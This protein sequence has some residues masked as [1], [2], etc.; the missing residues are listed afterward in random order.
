MSG[1]WTR[2]L[3]R[4]RDKTPI[5]WLGAGASCQAEPPL[6]T[7]GQ[8]VG[9]LQERETMWRPPSEL[10]D[11][12]AL[13]DH[14]VDEFSEGELQDFLAKQL[15]PDGRTPQ[16]GP[17]HRHLATLVGGRRFEAIIDT[18]YDMLLRHACEERGAAFEFS[19]L[20]RN[21]HLSDHDLPRYLALH[22][23]WDDW[24]SIVLTGRSFEAYES[25]HPLAI[26]EL[27]LQ[28]RRHPVLLVGCSLQDPRLLRWICALSNQD[29]RQLKR[30]VAVLGPG[31]RHALEQARW[32]DGRSYLEVLETITIKID[33][34]ESYDE[35]PGLF[36]ALASEVVVSHR[37]ELT[38]TIRAGERWAVEGLGE[39]IEVEPPKLPEDIDALRKLACK[40]LPCDQSGR[41]DPKTEG[42]YRA[43]QVRAIAA[44]EALAAVLPG[45]ARD[46][47]TTLVGEAAGEGAATLRLRATGDREQVDAAMLLPWEMISVDGLLPVGDGRLHLVREVVVPGGSSLPDDVGKP[48]VVAHV[49]TP[50]GSGIAE[51]D[52]E[53]AS[54]RIARALA[55]LEGFVRFTDWGTLDDLGEAVRSLG[56]APTIL[57]FSG[58]GRPGE[59]LFED[60]DGG[61]AWVGI[62]SLCERLSVATDGTLPAAIWLSCCYGAGTVVAPSK[63]ARDLAADVANAPELVRQASVASELHRRG[64]A[65]VL[66]YF[67][68]VSDPLAARLDC[69][70]FEALVE[71]GHT[72]DAVRRARIGSKTKLE[73]SY[74]WLRFPLA[75]AML[76]LYH[77]G[78]DRKL[79]VGERERGKVLEDGLAPE[80][81][82]FEGSDLQV[83]EHGYIG[84]RRLLAGLRRLRK[85]AK[86]R[87]IGLYGLGGLGKT[88]AMMRF[89]MLLV[90]TKRVRRDVIAIPAREFAAESTNAAG[91]VWLLDRIKTVIDTHPRKPEDWD[92]RFADLD[93]SPDRPAALARL[94]LA[95]A[96]GG[97]IY[98][99]NLETLQDA[100]ASSD[101][102]VPWRD[103]RLA[104]FFAVLTSEVDANTT[105]L[106]TSR[107]RPDGGCGWWRELG[108]CSK[109]E[110]FRMTGWWDPFARL[111]GVTRDRLTARIDGHP[112]SV[113]WINALLE[114][115]ERKRG[116]A[117][118][119]DSDPVQLWSTMIGPAVRGLGSTIEQ[120]LLLA[121][122]LSY[123]SAPELDLLAECTGIGRPVPGATVER[124]GDGQARLIA[125]GLLTRF[126]GEDAWGVHPLVVEAVQA[127]RGDQPW[128]PVG[129]SKLAAY[130]DHAGIEHGDLGMLRE[131]LDHRVAAL[132]W[133]EAISLTLRLSEIMR[134]L[135][136]TRL[137]HDFLDGLA[138]V[139]W[140]DEQQGH[141]SH[142]AGD[143]A[144]DVGEYE[145]AEARA[146]VSIQ[147]A[148]KACGTT[149]HPDVAVALHGLANVL[150]AQG[151]FEEAERTYAECIRVEQASYGTT[152]HP[153]IAKSLHGLANALSQQGKYKQAEDTYRESIRVKVNAYG[154]REHPSIG[155]SLHGLAGALSHQDKHQEAEKTYRESIRVKAKAFGS[156]HPLVASSLH[157][158]ALVLSKQGKL[159]EAERN[160]SESIRLHNK[161]YG[162]TSAAALPSLA[163]LASLLLHQDRSE[164][165]LERAA[166]AW[167]V[168]VQQGLRLEVAEIGPIY[169]AAAAACRREQDVL[170][171]LPVLLQTLE[172]FPAT[173]PVRV[174]IDAQLAGLFGFTQTNS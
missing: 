90:G 82:R 161:A 78:D 74:G 11:P 151:E 68:P 127:V 118:T 63:G 54:Y 6:P 16:P 2:D 51:L 79:I 7:L 162:G 71:S 116:I 102:G 50:K 34:L 81:I 70:L 24:S 56:V 174:R 12:Y 53:A 58:H 133:N 4:S 173:H 8:L 104:R 18:N 154:T 171:A 67:G 156:E 89:S 167:Q 9:T 45:K 137:R 95:I 143:A 122:L 87:A 35:L 93:E 40:G 30:W 168:A 22:G 141:W 26:H 65:Q 60:E 37:R 66:G 170:Q 148:E 48:R 169:L 163:N 92:R 146:R 165:A 134:R 62:D 100:A 107:H 103:E 135:G 172:Q 19:Q 125:L 147:M 149:S 98:L 44:G 27:E 69:D 119:R 166:D 76:A 88:A 47:L 130:W 86:K 49:A 32:T 152:E 105:V 20:D 46:L 159:E 155:S 140:P 110:I 85:K 15:R 101:A 142:H 83:L 131:A 106:M 57:H 97:V 126:G 14:F 113:E 144:Y 3:L 41:F 13:L 112:R 139:A 59:L 52:L 39:T 94:M 115:E 55:P 121:K 5:L 91:F 28:L 111:P 128:T 160:Y 21:L 10:V 153:S 145:L 138:N 1:D 42:L 38:V 158:L 124:L 84:R 120:D 114:Q 31:G 129:R 96:G 150:L 75:W 64:V 123:L 80:A 108:V 109:A 73:S 117:L 61:P 157:G 36:E 17:L 132:E 43:A 25:R 136:W 72:V 99:D 23:T 33:E 29:R 164:E 77:R